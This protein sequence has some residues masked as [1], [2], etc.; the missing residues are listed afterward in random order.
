MALT[1]TAKIR[2]L[3]NISTSEVSDADLSSLITEATREIMSSINI[4]VIR[5]EVDYIDA[6]REN[7]IDGVNKTYYVRNWKGKFI[8]DRNFDGTVDTTDITVYAVDSDDKETVATVSTIDY[9]DGKFTLDT[10]YDSSYKLYV[11][12]VY[13]YFDPITPDPLLGLAATYLVSSYA[14]LKRDV[15]MSGSQKFG[16][17]TIN[18]KLSDSY[19]QFYKRYEDIIKKLNSY[20]N[21]DSCWIESKVKI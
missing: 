14:Y 11:S 4:K 5:E 6:T 3:T 15:G 21:L 20:G 8:G 12:Y 9:D 16:N 18:T 19:G 10:A 13:T 7:D 17:V 2:L 1:T